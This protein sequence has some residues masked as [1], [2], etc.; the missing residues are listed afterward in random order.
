M[1]KLLSKLCWLEGGNMRKNIFFGLLIL[2]LILP[3]TCL[4]AG[5][6]VNPAE[7]ILENVPLGK[8]VAVSALSGPNSKLN[9]KNKNGSS[10]TYTINIFYTAE[11]NNFLKEGYTDIPDV[12]WIYPEKKEIE[13]EGNSTK[14]VELYLKVPKNKKYAGKKYQAI[15]EVKNKPKSG[16]FFNFACQPVILFSTVTEKKK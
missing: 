10:Y 4:A 16:D 6:A 14:A 13:I 12:S 2:S 15:I 11:T 5:L 3:Q 9:I 1:I 7:I 8:K